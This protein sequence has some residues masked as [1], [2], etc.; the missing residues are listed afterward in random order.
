M[1]DLISR[2][3]EVRPDERQVEWQEL[4]FTAFFHFGVNTFTNMEWGT[5]KEDPL[6]F[7]PIGLD[8]DQWCMAV[9]SAGINACILTVKHHDGFCLWDTKHTGHSVMASKKPVD[10]AALFVASCR[11]FGLKPGFYLSP[12]DMHE[13]AYGSGKA[14]D[15]FFCAQLEELTTGFGELYTLWFDGACGEGLSG[16]VQE[17]DW[18][19]YFKIIRKNQPNAVISIMGPDVRWI[20][21]E[22]GITR[23]SEWSVVSTRLQDRDTIAAASQQADGI[24]PLSPMDEDL[25]SIAA[26]ENER[27]LCWYP[28]EV[29]VSIRPG[30]FY[31]PEEDD[32]VRSVENLLH[33]YESSVGG[34]AVLLLNIPPDTNGRINKHDEVRLTELGKKLTEI[35]GT[36]LCTDAT[37]TDENNSD[38]SYILSDNDD[39]WICSRQSEASL[40]GDR[41]STV[42]EVKFPKTKKVRRLVLCEQ[43]RQSQRIEAFEVTAI[44]DSKHSLVYKGTTVGYKKICVF[45]SMPVDCIQVNITSSR[46]QPTI[47]HIAMH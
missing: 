29:D 12:W 20:G 3:I 5:G 23:E 46:G 28:A 18:E 1:K 6:V 24:K 10:I 45:D 25:G 17:Y 33:I 13:P 32:E 8:T 7:D 44:H 31:H 16:R 34:N 38:I 4:G 36:S 2:L 41:R 35:Y 11:R 21:N 27:S 9:K 22:A 15:D 26:L 40:V 19:R 14:Y 43:I 30:W 37:A 47:R 42:I 39:F